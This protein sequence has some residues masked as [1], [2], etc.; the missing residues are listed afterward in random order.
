MVGTRELQPIRDFADFAVS[1]R[2]SPASQELASDVIRRVVELV[3][4]ET[5]SLV[6]RTREKGTPCW[7]I[8][9]TYGLP[10]DGSKAFPVNLPGNNSIVAGSPTPIVMADIDRYPHFNAMEREV[11]H[12]W[13]IGSALGTA[14]PGP[15]GGPVGLLYVNWSDK[16][17]PNPHVKSLL[18]LAAKLV[19]S[20]IGPALA[21]E[22]LYKRQIVESNDE[23]GMAFLRRFATAAYRGDNLFELCRGLEDVLDVPLAV[24]TE[25]CEPMYPP[26]AGRLPLEKL[27]DDCAHVAKSGTPYN[28]NTADGGGNRMT[29]PIMTGTEVSGFL[30]A[31]NPEGLPIYPALKEAASI[32]AGKSSIAWRRACLSP[33]SIQGLF[34]GVLR[35]THRPAIFAEQSLFRE[36]FR[37]PYRLLLV[38]SPT[39][40]IED[41]L[42]KIKRALAPIERSSVRTEIDNNVVYVASEAAMRTS[43]MDRIKSSVA[44]IDEREGPVVL[45]ATPPFSTLDTVKSV[46]ENARKLAALAHSLGKRQVLSPDELGVEELL[47]RIDDSEW[48]NDFVRRLIGPILQHD[49]VHGGELT[50]SLECYLDN[51]CAIT[52]AAEQLYVHPN[53]LRYRL[54]KVRELMSNELATADERLTV[55]LALKL[56]RLAST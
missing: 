21:A 44:E 15:H 33:L 49:Q 28:S 7:A 53:T 50:K 23:I 14:L 19:G 31:W 48:S 22:S 5:G 29:V 52:A 51:N 56:S 20:F 39:Y 17:R 6:L 10:H 8:K 25:E 12:D 9:E 34:N 26:N 27:R 45:L 46:Y 43:V 13:G 55:H 38:N 37:G 11:V 36:D 4:G 2:D 54:A 35:G 40:Q 32:I 1:V 18:G 41:L 16:K 47:L 30:V 42:P 3:G 24:L